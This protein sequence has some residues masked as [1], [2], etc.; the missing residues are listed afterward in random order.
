MTPEPTGNNQNSED[1]QFFEDI[2]HYEWETEKNDWILSSRAIEEINTEG[3]D[4]L[5]YISRDGKYGLGTVNTSASKE[6]RNKREDIL[7]S[8]GRFSILPFLRLAG[9]CLVVY[10]GCFREVS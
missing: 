10:H 3:F 1:Q 7:F 6:K 2:V 5:N 9:R 8:K 4:A